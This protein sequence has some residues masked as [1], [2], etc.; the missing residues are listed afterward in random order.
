V[1]YVDAR[2]IATR[3]VQRRSCNCSAASCSTTCR[4]LADI[5]RFSDRRFQG[6]KERIKR[7]EKLLR[8]IQIFEPPDLIDRLIAA[9]IVLILYRC[10]LSGPNG[11]TAVLLITERGRFWALPSLDDSNISASRSYSMQ[12]TH[13]IRTWNLLGWIATTDATIPKVVPHALAAQRPVATRPPRLASAPQPFFTTT[14]EDRSTLCD[15]Q[16]FGPA[17]DVR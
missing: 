16:G 12:K 8:L 3:L 5:N 10:R 7:V 14:F 13:H 9:E 2:P 11:S 17:L 4:R 1:I 6:V 15:T